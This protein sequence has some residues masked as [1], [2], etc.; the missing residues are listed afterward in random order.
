MTDRIARTTL[1]TL[2]VRANEAPVEGP[3]TYAA[4]LEGGGPG[5]ATHLTLPLIDGRAADHLVVVWGR[6]PLDGQHWKLVQELER[7]RVYAP[8][9]V[10][11]SMAGPG[12]VAGR[13][14]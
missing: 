4:V 9:P 8:V 5:A 2:T 11:I 10:A 14:A 3:S 1:I 7:E 12:Q 6:D 13:A